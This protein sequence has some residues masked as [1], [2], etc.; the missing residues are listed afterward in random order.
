MKRRAL[1][2]V[3]MLLGCQ[4]A[5]AQEAAV[6]TGLCIN[7]VMASNHTSVEDSF[8]RHPDWAEI[9]NASDEPVSL[10]GFCLS[11]KKDNLDRFRFPDGLA[12]APKITP[13]SM[14][15]TGDTILKAPSAS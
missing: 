3:V 10:D 8:G 12:L 2:L 15:C 1:L 6:E 7:E 14:R 5:F 11:D 13:K 4:T 9:F